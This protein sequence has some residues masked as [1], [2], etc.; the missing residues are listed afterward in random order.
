MYIHISLGSLSLS[1]LSFKVLAV[2][3]RHRNLSSGLE[4]SGAERDSHFLLIIGRDGDVGVRIQSLYECTLSY[5]LLGHNQNFPF[6]SMIR[7]ICP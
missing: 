5:G 4:T 7:C 1:R 3:D 6:L 2:I